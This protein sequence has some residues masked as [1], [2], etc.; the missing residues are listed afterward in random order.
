[1]N[2]N[3]IYKH[4]MHVASI[5]DFRD[6]VINWLIQAALSAT[7]KQLEPFTKAFSYTG[8]EQ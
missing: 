2:F 7:T 6:T 4:Y 3:V 5:L 8:M 1:M